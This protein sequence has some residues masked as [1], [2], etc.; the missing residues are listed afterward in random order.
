MRFL[1]FSSIIFSIVCLIIS[2]RIIAYIFF[3]KPFLNKFLNNGSTFDIK[4]VGN[5]RVTSFTTVI[6]TMFRFKKSKHSDENYLKSSKTMFDSIK[7]PLIA[8]VDNFWAEKFIEMCK[9]KNI[10]GLK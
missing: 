10:T 2:H 8:F 3:Y 7:G 9:N 1:S 5:Q 6:T 4:H